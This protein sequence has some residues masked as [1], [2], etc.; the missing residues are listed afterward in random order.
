MRETVVQARCCDE[1]RGAQLLHQSRHQLVLMD[2]SKAP[3]SLSKTSMSQTTDSRS[4]ALPAE[5]VAEIALISVLRDTVPRTW[6]PFPIFRGQF[7]DNLLSFPA[8]DTEACRPLQRDCAST[9]FVERS[10]FCSLSKAPD[11]AESSVSVSAPAGFRHAAFE[12]GQVCRTWRRAVFGHAALWAEGGLLN[13][14]FINRAKD[15][16]QLFP[17]KLINPRPLCACFLPYCLPHVASAEV[18]S[19]STFAMADDEF[20]TSEALLG[21]I[22]A[23]IASEAGCK[24]RHIDIQLT[25]CA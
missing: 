12:C 24:L 17:H 22:G 2:A 16:N 18:I 13:L 1:A 4:P 14:G 10:L 11:T 8:K 20:T 7:W 3:K 5:I 19:L 9:G 6:S 21:E 23:A 25:R 15:R